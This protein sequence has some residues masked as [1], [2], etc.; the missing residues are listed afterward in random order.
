MVV[1]VLIVK[2]LHALPQHITTTT[3]YSAGKIDYGNDNDNDDHHND[4]NTSNLLFEFSRPKF[5]SN[6]TNSVLYVV[7]CYPK[8]CK[9]YL[10]IIQLKMVF[11]K[12]PDWIC[13]PWTY[14]AVARGR[15]L[16]W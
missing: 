12:Q 11:M 10:V 9:E 1:A 6:Q 4:H 13:R 5:R 14:R 7:S 8:E 16:P 3:N 15:R 2:M